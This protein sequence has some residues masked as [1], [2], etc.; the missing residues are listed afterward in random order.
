MLYWHQISA[1]ASSSLWRQSLRFFYCAC[2]PLC[3]F[4]TKDSFSQDLLVL[5][6]SRNGRTP[7]IY[8]S[9][10]SNYIFKE[11]IREPNFWRA[12]EESRNRGKEEVRHYLFITL[13]FIYLP[14]LFYCDIVFVLHLLC[15]RLWTHCGR[16][17]RLTDVP[18]NDHHRNGKCVIDISGP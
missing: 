5:S 15:P 3:S 17:Q 10:C 4:S 11:V 14:A 6:K 2:P 9:Q 8:L 16:N 13:K 7:W 12:K 18:A 1:F